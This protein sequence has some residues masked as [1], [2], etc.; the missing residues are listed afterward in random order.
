M[1][2]NSLGGTESEGAE[3]SAGGAIPSGVAG[4]FAGGIVGGNAG[5]DPGV[6]AG[7]GSGDASGSEPGTVLLGCFVFARS[8]N[9]SSNGGTFALPGVVG[10]SEAAAF[11]GK[12][13]STGGAVPVAGEVDG[14]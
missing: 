9:G 5:S 2:G 7:A 14:G 8:P 3:A 12:V 1:L 10:E 13:G 6:G 11:G 4:L